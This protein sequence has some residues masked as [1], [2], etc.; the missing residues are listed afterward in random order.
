[1][2]SGLNEGNNALLPAEQ[3]E[4]RDDEKRKQVGFVG[5]QK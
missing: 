4:N 1:M 3:V 2:S 5:P